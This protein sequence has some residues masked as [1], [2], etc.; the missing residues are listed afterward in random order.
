MTILL[1]G[2]IF[3]III[4]IKEKESSDNANDNAII[5]NNINGTVLPTRPHPR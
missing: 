2:T 4:I 5:I 1:R 3:I